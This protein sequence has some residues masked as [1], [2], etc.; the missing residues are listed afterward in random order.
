LDVGGA[1]VSGAPAQRRRLA[2]LALLASAGDR[3]LSREKAFGYL[4]PEHET[5]RARHQLSESIYVLRRLLG[6]TAIAATLDDL[7]LDSSQVW[8]DVSALR[9][10]LAATNRE[11][12]VSLYAG[13]FL[14]GFFLDNAPEFDQW[15]TNEREALTASTCVR[16][17]RWLSSRV[18]RLQRCR[19]GNG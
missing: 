11:L 10:A 9:A 3:G 18:S 4:W 8:S 6:E 1:P 13:R 16:S 12:A 17:R 7:R 19:G 2:L 14:D 5:A 15:A